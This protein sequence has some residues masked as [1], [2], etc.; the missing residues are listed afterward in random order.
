MRATPAP[1]PP[2]TSDYP[3]LTAC[4][5]ILIVVTSYT[6]YKTVTGDPGYIPLT[7]PATV[8]T[9]V[10]E[11]AAEDKL[12]H[13]HFCTT[14]RVRPR[15]CQQGARSSRA[16]RSSAMACPRPSSHQIRKPLRSKHDRYSNR[17]VARFDHYCPWVFNVV[18]LKNHRM[19]VIYLSCSLL[20]QA[21]Y[22]AAA[23]ICTQAQ[24]G[25]GKALPD[26]NAVGARP[27][28]CCAHAHA[29]AG[30]HIDE[31]KAAE[32][33]LLAPKVCGAFATNSFAIYTAL[34]CIGNGLWEGLTWL[35]QMAQVRQ[36]AL[37]AERA[38][39]RALNWA[40]PA[41][42]LAD[43]PRSLRAPR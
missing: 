38:K 32:T 25:T 14:C 24:T 13:R 12:D 31:S 15:R 27:V 29:D 40:R 11:L 3:F 5:L 7:D 42:F 10:L 6:C 28:P 1:F 22:T 23:F 18:G 26:T 41:T 34:W 8:R 2:G 33:C 35:S 37:A 39:T 21:L 4:I 20:L 43:Q 30:R 16:L 19:F 9:T 17:C 36:T